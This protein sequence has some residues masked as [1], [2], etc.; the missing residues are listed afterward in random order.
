MDW[1]RERLDDMTSIEHMRQNGQA[2]W[3][4]DI[5]RGLIRRGE[6]KRL[7]E[8]DGVSGAT[9]N[10]KTFEEA[11]NESRDYDDALDRLAETEAH[12]DAQAIYERMSIVDVRMAADELR[13]VY[14]RTHGADGFANIE[15]SPY[16][17]R[18]A[19]AS[20]TEARR[21]WD[22]VHRPNLM[23]TIPATIE[24]IL[25]LESLLT[26]GINVNVTLIFSLAQYEAVV[27]AYLRGIERAPDPSG[28]ASVA[29]VCVSRIDSAVDGDLLRIG[30]PQALALH[31]K[32]ATANAKQIYRRFCSIFHSDRFA[33]LRLRGVRP[34]RLLWASTTRKAQDYPDVCYIEELIGPDTIAAVAPGTLEAFRQH[35]QVRGITLHENL[36]EAEAALASL[37]SL[38]LDLNT[39][40]ESL[41]SYSV[42]AIAGSLDR[43]LATLD[44]KRR[45]GV[46]S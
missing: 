22:R 18:D 6:L 34:K 15:I 42:A 45:V 16:L 32:I 19:Q 30:T 5:N 2:I 39:V 36:A 11:V 9:S 31:G 27:R 7:I 20:V 3:L 46:K 14:D 10:L 1:A 29:S 43:L 4:D 24:G 8:Q 33:G 37:R 44:R 35:G 41:Q 38:G 40:T 23:V 13:P 25:V 21:L 17:A 28:T 26:E 12:I